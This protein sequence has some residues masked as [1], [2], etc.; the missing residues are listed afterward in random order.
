MYVV[1]IFAEAIFALLT[2][3]GIGALISLLLTKYASAPTWIYAIFI[4]LGALT[5][6]Y[7]MIK[8]IVSA[9][10]ALDKLE[11][12]HKAK[13]NKENSVNNNSKNGKDKNEQE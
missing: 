2:P 5:G 10:S 3:V 1:N 12:Q 11:A 4:P 13:L 6:L 8:F 7:S 9:M